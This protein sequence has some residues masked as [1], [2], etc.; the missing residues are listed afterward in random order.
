MVTTTTK[1]T[2]LLKHGMAW[3]TPSTEINSTFQ[4]QLNFEY[5]N[6]T[7][8]NELEQLVILQQA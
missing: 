7:C 6:F 2:S 3:L 4:G 8:S 5:S 1:T